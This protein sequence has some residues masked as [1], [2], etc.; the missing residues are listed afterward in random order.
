MLK[1]L[2]GLPHAFKTALTIPDRTRWTKNPRTEPVWDDRNRII[3][4]LIPPQSRVLDLGSGAQTLRRH[5]AHSCSYVPCDLVQSSPDCEVVD[6]NLGIYPSMAKTYDYSVAS[7][8]LEYLR[9]PSDFLVRV[10]VYAPVTILTY[11]PARVKPRERLRR[12]SNGFV[13]HMGQNELEKLFKSSGFRFREVG[14]WLGQIV[15]RLNTT[16]QKDSDVRRCHK[17]A[18]A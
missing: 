18:E 7:G 4:R 2:Q 12:L 14:V 6:F 3:A 8:V 5:L 11:E 13:N 1:F 17:D 9:N 16:S 15:Y 10:Q